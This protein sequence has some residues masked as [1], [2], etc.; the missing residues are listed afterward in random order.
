MQH[1]VVVVAVVVVV[2]VVVVVAAGVAVGRSNKLP[3]GLRNLQAFWAGGL[4]WCGG[5]SGGVGGGDSLGLPWPPR[6]KAN[7]EAAQKSRNSPRMA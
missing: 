6:V 4:G 2:V 3:R 5:W 7:G 1:L